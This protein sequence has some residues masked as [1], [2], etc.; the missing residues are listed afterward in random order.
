M[1]L[2]EYESRVADG[3]PRI[4]RSTLIVHDPKYRINRTTDDG[5]APS[6]QRSNTI[7]SNEFVIGVFT[8]GLKS[9]Q[10]I[11]AS[12]KEVRIRP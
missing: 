2:I 7:Q 3:R 9:F 10:W 1:D 4:D 11:A 8:R 12:A 5:D 6:F